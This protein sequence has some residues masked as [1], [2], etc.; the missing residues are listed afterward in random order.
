M[1]YPLNGK[2]GHRNSRK[3]N[4]TLTAVTGRGLAKVVVFDLKRWVIC[5]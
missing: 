1:R 3:C 5:D 4:N 2:I